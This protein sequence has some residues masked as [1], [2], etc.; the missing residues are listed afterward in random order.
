M[1]KFTSIYTHQQPSTGRNL[2]NID[3]GNIVY[4]AFTEDD[5]GDVKTHKA[6]E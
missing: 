6:T 4:S 1:F 3:D 5:P 2:Q